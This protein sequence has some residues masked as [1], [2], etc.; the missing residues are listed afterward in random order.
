MQEAAAKP[1]KKYN[2]SGNYGEGDWIEHA[3]FGLG[4]VQTFTA[5]NKITVRFADTTRML[6]CNRS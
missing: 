5:P 1:H 3:T 6:V 2:M 4:C